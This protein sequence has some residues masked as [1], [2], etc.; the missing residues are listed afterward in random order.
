[1]PQEVITHIETLC[2]QEDA[3]P[4]LMFGDRNQMPFDEPDPIDV[5]G[6]AIIEEMNAGI[7][8][9]PVVNE[10]NIPPVDQHDQDVE[11][12]QHV[13]IPVA[14]DNEVIEVH[15]DLVEIDYDEEPLHHDP[16]P[17]AQQPDIDALMDARY[18]QR[19][20][21][22]N[23]RPRR[24]RDYGH[25]HTTLEGIALTQYSLNKGIKVFKEQG[26]EAVSKELSQLHMRQVLHP[27]HAQALRPEQKQRALPYLMFLTEKRNGTIKARGCA[28]GRSQREYTEKSDAASPTVAIE[29]VFI[30]CCIDAREG[31][32]VAT[33]D[34]PGAF[35]HADMDQTVHMRL[36]GKM[37]ELLVQLDPKLYRKYL[38]ISPN[39]RPILY[40]ELKKALYGTLR[41]ALLFWRMLSAQLQEWGF[42]I[43]PYDWCVANKLIDGNQC[44]IVW[45]VDDLK[46]SHV[47]PDVVSSV[48]NDLN[49]VFGKEAPLTQTRGKLHDYLGMTISFEIPGKVQITMFDYIKKMLNDLPP[50][51]DGIAVTPAAN[52]LFDVDISGKVPLDEPNAILFHHLVAKLL[53]LCK[54]ARPDIQTAVAFLSTRVKSPDGHD[55]RKLARVMRYLRATMDLPLTLEASHISTIKWWVDGAF[56]VHPDMRSHTGVVMSLGKGAVYASSLKQKLNTKSSTEAEL[57]GVDDA[58][59]QILWTRYF[60]EAQGYTVKDTIIYQDNM[61]AML[62][63]KNGRGSSGKRTR[64]INIRYFFVRDRIQSGEVHVLHCPTSIMLADFFTKP[65]Q[66]TAF[67]TFR[68]LIL[69]IDQTNNHGS[70]HRSVLDNMDFKEGNCEQTSKKTIPEEMS[71]TRKVKNPTEYSGTCKNEVFTSSASMI[72]NSVSNPGSVTGMKNTSDVNDWTLVTKRKKRK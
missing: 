26:I 9:D 72:Q 19:Q 67:R 52:H 70:D 4:G 49:Q 60:I 27:V 25:L 47:N 1:M 29:S 20:S 69:N 30:T 23:L 12:H 31:R 43:N 6:R 71:D 65:L 50:D 57:V 68:A 59:G 55:Y 11:E 42:V 28:D 8:A 17:A 24:P 37:A 10:D 32:D 46:I 14:G 58:M 63:E 61:S 64:H 2:N 56:A 44:T 22:Y 62:L 38:I 39:G 16:V 53:F 45:H 21:G 13:I 5:N 51:M 3:I 7:V 33:V 41:A 54:R 48:I 18:G 40:V 36:E 15:D 66:G 35:M 34:I